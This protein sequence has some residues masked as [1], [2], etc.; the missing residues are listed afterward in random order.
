MM[1]GV[2]NRGIHKIVHREPL[3]GT[4]AFIHIEWMDYK[5][6]NQCKVQNGVANNYQSK[7]FEVNI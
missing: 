5:Y 6:F 3:K 4:N 7:Y 2:S 1:I